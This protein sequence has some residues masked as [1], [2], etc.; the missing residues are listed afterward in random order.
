[1]DYFS[2]DSLFLHF[3]LLDL[4]FLVLLNLLSSRLTTTG[5]DKNL[6]DKGYLCRKCPHLS[7]HVVCQSLSV[8]HKLDLVLENPRLSAI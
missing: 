5:L 3:S 8:M 6:F 4:H 2:T 7:P 1:M